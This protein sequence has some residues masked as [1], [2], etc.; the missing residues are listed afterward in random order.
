MSCSQWKE[1][2]LGEIYDFSSGLSKKRED[3]GFGAPFLTFKEVFNNYFLPNELIELV[4]S[5]E[6]EQLKCSVKRGDVFLTRTSENQDELGLSSVALKD[7]PHATF[8]GFTKRLRPRT[9][10]I[11]L[12]EFAGYYF[13]SPRF[14]SQV[15]SMSSITTRASLN[16]SMLSVLK[17]VA[18]PLEEQKKIF[19]LLSSLDKKIENNTLMNDTLEEIAQAIFKRWFIDFEFPK[20]DGVPFRSGGGNFI[21]TDFG[22][23]PATWEI[24]TLKEFISVQN[25]FAFKSKDFKE[26]GEFGVVK[27]KNISN[28]VVDINNTQFINQSIAEKTNSKFLVSGSDVLIAMTGAEVGKIGVV[29]QTEKTLYL[30]QR[31]GKLKQKVNGGKAYAF[32]SLNRPSV[33]E[34]IKS[35]AMGSAQPNISSTGLESIKV[36]NP[37]R[38]VLDKFGRLVNSIIQKYASNLYQNNI[39]IDLRKTLLPKLTSGDIRI[40]EAEKEVEE[41][42]QKSN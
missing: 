32:Y 9:S 5:S 24:S 22:L 37:S 38:D 34:Q 16:N 10:D 18:P 25:G 3:F 23:I 6:K 31:V 2:S 15:T 42:L 19:L 27:I 11:I 20:E 30:N 7:Y 26:H 41:C 1:Y 40:P 13:R 35:L 14:R 28:G 4:N 17:I 39:L 8:N 36:V 29:P 33:Q 21:N 12:P